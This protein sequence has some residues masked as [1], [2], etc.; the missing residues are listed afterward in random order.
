MQD[1]LARVLDRAVTHLVDT[2][3]EVGSW[4]LPP[5]PRILETGFATYALEVAGGADAAVVR[6]RTWLALNSTSLQHDPIALMTENAMRDFALAKTVELELDRPE[7]ANPVLRWRTA[8]LQALALHA[9]QWAEVWGADGDARLAELRAELA[10]RYETARRD[11]LRV[12]TIVEIAAA[13]VIVEGHFGATEAVREA[14]E[15]IKSVQAA[16]GSIATMP[17]STAMAV[18]A[19]GLAEPEGD[20]VARGREYLLAQQHGNGG[21]SLITCENWD[22]IVT[23]WAAREHPLFQEKC[24]PRAVRYLESIQHPDGGFPYAI[25]LQPDLDSTAAALHALAGLTSEDVVE[26]SLGLYR[27]HQR[28]DGLWN[29]YYYAKDVPTDDC[30]AHI[31]SALS[32][33]PDAETPSTEETTR[34]LAERFARG[35]E[36]LCVYRNRPYTVDTI[37]AAIGYDHPAVHA[38][39]REVLA[40]Q[41]PD[42]GWGQRAGEASC[43]SAT[44]AAVGLLTHT[45][46]GDEAALDR[47]VRYLDS[48][49]RAD[50]TWPG[51]PEL[52][53]PRP[54]LSYVPLE[55]HAV[56][57]FGLMARY[58]RA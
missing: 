28:P 11:R 21:W 34:W 9:G 37:G 2:Q 1:I 38:A 55:S 4:T 22:S 46:L 48:T 30:V 53:G 52:I 8:L 14:A 29:T 20:A 5:E 13:R 3:D 33:F 56:T 17:I 24:L 39:T 35:E 6:G 44:G 41:N 16:D 31:V 54:L 18:L 25:V 19:L 47:A 32:L 49:Q 45:G 40:A 50:G 27:E 58:R 10:E 43:A 7:L 36:F 26:R 15:T 42:G 12:W 57:V 23:V 51:P